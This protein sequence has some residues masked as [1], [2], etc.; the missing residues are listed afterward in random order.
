MHE[1]IIELTKDQLHMLIKK[2]AES[3][4]GVT[5]T[6]NIHIVLSQSHDETRVEG[7]RVTVTSS[8]SWFGVPA[9]PEDTK[10][11]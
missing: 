9:F 4:P 2:F 10:K 1:L 7:A 6:K 5:S 11:K 8:R 3:L